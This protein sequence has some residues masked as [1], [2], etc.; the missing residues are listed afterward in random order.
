MGNI[1]DYLHWRGDLTFAQSKF[2]KVDNLILS[3]LAYVEL[4]EVMPPEDS[5]ET[6]TIKEASSHYF[7]LHDMDKISTGRLI[8]HDI[9][10]LFFTMASTPRFSN[11]QLSHY[12]NHID[13]EAEKQFSALTIQLDENTLFIAFRGTDDTIVGWKEDFNMSF[14]TPVPSQTEAVEYLKWIM[15]KSRCRL[16]LGGHSK[17]GNLAVYAAAFSGYR[18]RRR[19]IEVYNNDGPGF[20]QQVIQTENYKRIQDKI[21]TYVPQSSVVGMLLEHEE[22]YR[23]VH[24]SQK[25][26]Y[27]HDP[28]SWEVS[29]KDFVYE[30][31]L[32]PASQI[33][34]RTLKEWILQME[35]EQ[36]AEFVDGLFAII[37]Q[38][39]YRTL[40]ELNLRSLGGMMRSFQSMDEETKQILQKTIKSLIDL[41]KKNARNFRKETV[42][43]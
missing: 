43:K 5:D 14:Q 9:I 29:G 32:T 10:T 17:G 24:S 3:M 31:V 22:E 20:T 37:A 40:S 39:E 35:D 30:E 19:V 28:F 8:S 4:T 11:L 38:K 7:T 36:K 42:V 6:I 27:Q 15:S 12:V 1:I 41:M 34:D 25:G 26:L 13:L 23:V 21:Y 33:F 18:A 16:Y 2:N